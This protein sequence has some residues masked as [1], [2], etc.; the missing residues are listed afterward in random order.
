MGVGMSKY[1][2]NVKK[3][4]KKERKQMHV[5]YGVDL[6]FHILTVHLDIIIF[7]SPTDVQASCLKKKQY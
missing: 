5:H 4:R 1:G 2:L 3:E 7:F 6:F